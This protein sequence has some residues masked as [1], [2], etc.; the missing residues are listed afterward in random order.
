MAREGSASA[1]GGVNILAIDSTLAGEKDAMQLVL[2]DRNNNNNDN[3]LAEKTFSDQE[4][5]C[6]D[7]GDDMSGVV[8]RETSSALKGV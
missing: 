4:R 8:G 3:T 5:R 7:V 6:V 2:K 1:T